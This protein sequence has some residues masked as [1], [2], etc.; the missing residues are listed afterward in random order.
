MSMLFRRHRHKKPVKKKVVEEPKEEL[1][2]QPV[3][4]VRK[5]GPNKQAKT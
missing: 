4:E 2:L 1:Q 5:R 3:V